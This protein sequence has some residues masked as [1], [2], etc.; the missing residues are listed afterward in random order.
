[1]ATRRFVVLRNLSVK[2]ASCNK[3]TTFEDNVMK[4][5]YVPLY[6][7]AA[8]HWLSTPPSKRLVMA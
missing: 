8:K 2:M 4:V 6:T 5:K 1:M 3:E 7:E